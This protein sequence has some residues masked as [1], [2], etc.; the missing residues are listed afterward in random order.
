MRGLRRAHNLAA[1]PKE[2]PLDRVRRDKDVRGFRVKMVFSRAQ[3]PEALL[4]YL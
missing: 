2:V 4:G 1:F 3:E